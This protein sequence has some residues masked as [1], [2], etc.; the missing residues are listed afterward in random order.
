MFARSTPSSVAVLA[1][2]FRPRLPGLTALFLAGCSAGPAPPSSVPSTDGA[3]A[4]D[5]RIV[6]APTLLRRL[7]NEE[8]DNTVRDL[9]GD[10]E[11]PAA[12]FP[13]DEAVGGFEN[14]TVTPI[15]QTGVERYME[16]AEGL[17][18]RAVKHLDTL[19]PCPSGSP[20]A[21]C[22]GQLLDTLGR[23]IY[24]RPLDSRERTALL[25]LFAQ[26]HERSGYTHAI[27]LV[28]TA[29]LE[30][31]SFLY[32]AEPADGSTSARELTGYELATR[33]SYLLWA[34]TPDDELLDAAA[35]GALGNREGLAEAARRLLADRRAQD[36]VRSFH[37]QWLDLRVLDTAS[38][39]PALYPDFTPELKDAMV[40]ETLRFTS[41]A[42]F[43]GGDSV[44]TLLTS[45]K[46][47]INAGLARI[48]GVPAPPGGDFQ[49][50][51]LPAEQRSG[52]LTHAS[53]MAALSGADETSPIL[54]GK[55]VRERLLC[56]K[57][58]PPPPD[59]NARPP[60]FDPRLSKRQRFERHRTDMSC[61]FC[62]EALDPPGFAFEHYD[63]LGAWREREGVLPV[64]ATGILT[65]TDDVDGPFDGVV[66]L[67]ARLSTS[68]QV[69]RCVATQWFRA[70]VGRVERVEDNP[71]LDAIFQTF[72]RSGFDARELII[73]IVTSDAFRRVGFAGQGAP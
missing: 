13:P 44:A 37:R 6:A 40:E 55:F 1:R 17:A 14:N 38:K 51:D 28:L 63:A 52:V 70:A 24:R 30:S 16:A 67:G 3:V 12:A 73:A 4:A 10:R 66:A 29:M 27:E 71:S 33:L 39:S 31:P 58:A 50:V 43:Q 65:G 61:A 8:Y 23:R 20:E 7:T 42:V 49:L 18:A 36:G 15:S 47:F 72:A 22:A 69:R 19:A 62:H 32:R 5:V 48:Y 11:R 34:S 56:E 60:A 57:I 21:A 2:A 54:R 9:L 46:S 26:E 41:H 35:A 68:A 53:L 25:A 45:H 59:V 64:D